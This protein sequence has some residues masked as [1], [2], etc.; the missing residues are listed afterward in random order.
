M[1]L[2]TTAAMSLTG[3]APVGAVA[4]SG[5]GRT[6][7]AVAKPPLSTREQGAQPRLGECAPGELCL[8][9]RSRFRGERRTYELSSVNI[10]SCVPLPAGA[11]ARSF[12]NRT[13]R[14]VTVY[15]SRECADTGEFNTHP[16]GSWTPQGAYRVRAVKIWEK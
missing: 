15:Q 9:A 16:S 10:E 4:S 14:P 2:A 13:G 1:L 11:G 8:W 5:E 12:A 6:T 3:V 7:A